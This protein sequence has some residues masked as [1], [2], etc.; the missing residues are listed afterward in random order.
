MKSATQPSP[1]VKREAFLDCIGPGSPIYRLFDCIPGVSFFAKNA[2]FE[3]VCANRHFIERFGLSDENEIIG[4]SDFDL[5]PA[6][7]AEKFRRDDEEV[8]KTGEA[9]WHIVE[10]F[11][12]RQGLPDWFVTDKMPVID[13]RG[14]VIGVM[15]IVRAYGS[16]PEEVHTHQQIA[17][18]VDHIRSH[19]R[20]KI[21]VDELAELTHL[22]TRQ[23]HRKFMEAFGMGPQAVIM[24]LRIQAAC[25]LL[26][27]PDAMISDVARTVGFTDQSSFTQHF[28]KHMGATPLRYRRQF[29]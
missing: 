13:K 11:F 8:M 27:N 21:T 17:R 14:R 25:E 29:A 16:A 15:G 20:Q 6:R 1:Q 18:A 23:L 19:F 12:N 22:S 10:L 26:G 9:K 7:L 5:L 3:F 24:K 4:K 2:A 28:H